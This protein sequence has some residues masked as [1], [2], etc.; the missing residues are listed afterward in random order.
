MT[1]CSRVDNRSSLET[2]E[3]KTSGEHGKENQHVEVG[4]HLGMN[5]R[6]PQLGSK[7]H[8]NTEGYFSLQQLNGAAPL[9]VPHVITHEL[10]V[11]WAQS[12]QD[13]VSYRGVQ[14]STAPAAIPYLYHCFPSSNSC[15]LSYPQ[16]AGRERSCS[17]ECA[18]W[19]W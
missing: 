11:L 2:E 9:G 3:I 16:T 6:H 8:V 7:K 5:E 19:P 12:Y 18:G 10:P 17:Y 13:L 4:E 14:Q 15:S 1:G